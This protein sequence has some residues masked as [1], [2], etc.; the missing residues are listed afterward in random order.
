MTILFEREVEQL[1]RNFLILGSM[2]EGSVQKA[3]DSLTEYDRNL[4]SSVVDYDEEID[5]KEIEIEEECLKV[6]ALHQPVAA[7]LRFIVSILKINSDLERI[8]DLATNVAE[9]SLYL[10]D[11]PDIKIPQQIFDMA[12]PVQ[13]MIKEALDSLVN[14]N[15]EL[16]EQVIGSD[17]EVD[18]IHRQMYHI[19]HGFL[20][21]DAYHQPQWLQ[22]LA[23]SRYLERMADHATN[24]AEDV[25]YMIDGDIVRH[26]SISD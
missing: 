19:I 22:V 3:I 7:D 24:I 23:I 10:S 25:I 21:N 15:A 26:T 20:A 5:Q 8:G 14:K 6:L 12:K 1:K 18:E 9:R 2:V 17:H 4:A 11:Y 13:L 16:A